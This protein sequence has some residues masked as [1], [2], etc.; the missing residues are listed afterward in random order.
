VKACSITWIGRA[1]MGRWRRV[2]LALR[3]LL[4]D[5]PWWWPE[6]EQTGLIYNGVG[7]ET[8]ENN[9]SA[10]VRRPSRTGRDRSG[11]GAPPGRELGDHPSAFS[12]ESRGKRRPTE[13]VQDRQGAGPAPSNHRGGATRSAGQGQLSCVQPDLRSGLIRPPPAPCG[14]RFGHGKHGELVC[15]LRR[16]HGGGCA[17]EGWQGTAQGWRRL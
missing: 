14:A 3:S 9:A 1:I 2:A 15:G 16:G 4:D 17:L 12:R 11:P 10:I 7:D 6:S 8:A 5:A 13:P